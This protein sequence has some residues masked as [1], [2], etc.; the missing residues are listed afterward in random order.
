MHSQNLENKPQ[1]IANIKGDKARAEFINIFKEIQKTKTKLDQHTDLNDEQID[2]IEQTMPL[3]TLRAYKSMYLETAKRLQDKRDKGKNVPDVVEQ[4][5]F[6]FVLFSSTLIDYDY[7]MTLIAKHSQQE[8]TNK[9]NKEQLISLLNS[10]SNMMDEKDTMI[11]YINSLEI[12]TAL[13]EDDIKKGYKAF[14]K[15][16]YS[17]ELN[18]MALRRNLEPLSLQSFVSHILDRFI[19]DGE[20]LTDLFSP[21]ELGWKDR[22]VK[23]LALMKELSPL[24]KAIAN[25]KKI[26]GLEVY[27]N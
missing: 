5:D 12:E 16:K 1:E 26:S 10:N 23:E 15:N 11:A 6:E 9:M 13:N 3:D 18:E 20:L 14:K 2:S 17:K 4:L 7:I 25:N 24:L 21:L 27:D 8:S 22:R 19:F